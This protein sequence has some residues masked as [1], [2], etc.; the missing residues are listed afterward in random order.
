ML[1]KV[2]SVMV[3]SIGT[4][5]VYAGTMGADSQDYNLAGFYAGLG[6]GYTT[7]IAKDSFSVAHAL[8]TPAYNRSIQFT[9]SAVLFDGHIGYGNYF[10][11]N[12]YLG[13][14]ASIYYTPLQH[15]VV[16]P[17]SA[18]AGPLLLGG[19]DVDTFTIKPIYNIDAVLGYEIYPH[20]LPFLEAGISFAN[21]DVNYNVLRTRTNLIT[22][23][24]ATYATALNDN[25]YLTGYNVGVGA[26]YQLK[27]NWFFSS[28]LVY[29][30]LGKSS[31]NNLVDVPGS[32]D[33]ETRTKTKTNQAVSL[34]LSISYL[35]P[36]SN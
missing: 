1:N 5:G 11:Q 12:M 7:L 30:Y 20:L 13:A 14:K 26:N 18:T 33:V 2:F 16:A 24:S 4:M 35:F 10:N 17:F 36:I 29:N 32:A 34:L 19:V 9:D 21:V 15:D 22:G 25:Q 28:E 27:K 23:T 3:L 6:T 8:P 31:V